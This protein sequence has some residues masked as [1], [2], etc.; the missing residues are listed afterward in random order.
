MR[1]T[2]GEMA[3]RTGIP[4]TTLRYYDR[5]GL[6]PGLERTEGGQRVFRET[7][8]ETLLM[9]DCLKKS[10]LSLSEIRDFLVLAGQGDAT[11][12][13]RLALFQD[14]RRAVL[15]QSEAL[16]ETLALLDYKCWYY[17]TAMEGG[18]EA[19]VR[20]LPEEEIPEEQRAARRK[21]MDAFGPDHG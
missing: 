15:E 14:R 1:Y 18:S 8:L 19:A 10:G 13:E 11:I 12:A 5:R 17:E 4:A 2:V 3:E 20:D 7:D 16:R 21:L 6:L 9:I